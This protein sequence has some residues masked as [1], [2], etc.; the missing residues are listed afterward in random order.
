MNNPWN[1]IEIPRANLNVLRVS[2]TH[3]LPLYWGKD[4]RG[5]YNFLADIPSDAMPAKKELPELIGIRASVFPSGR[6]E[7]L[8]FT[9]ND[10]QDWGI[11]LALCTDLIHASEKAE[12]PTAA[13]KIIL[14]RLA[15]W[16]EFLKRPRNEAMTE[17]RIKG[18]IG[19]LLFL[20]NPLAA[21]FGWDYAVS[22]WKGP[23]GAPQDFAVHDTAIEVKCQAGSSR[24][25][26]EITSVEQLNA[27][28]PK[29]FLVVQT[30]ASADENDKLG[31][32]LNSLVS[33][34]RAGM[35]HASS[36]SQEVFETLLF[37]AGYLPLPDYAEKSFQSVSMHSFEVC[38]NFPRL[39]GNEIPDGIEKISYQLSL[40]AIAHFESEVSF[41]AVSEND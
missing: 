7:K 19:E 30:L 17:A 28:L 23:E 14:L 36:A 13:V 33:R 20:E 25:F 6:S 27:Q 12:S 9:L 24:P 5:L 1:N 37:Q 15:R 8:V 38:E 21:K 39:K 35:V 10:T 3:P 26:V 18:L 40:D 4:S 16:R 34:I 11:F 22:F 31:F 29:F 32:S 2:A 41:P